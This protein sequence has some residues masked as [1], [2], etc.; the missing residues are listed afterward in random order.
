MYTITFYVG[1]AAV[2]NDPQAGEGYYDY[3]RRTML[4]EA[5]SIFGGYSLSEVS[6]GWFDQA[7]RLVE[8]TSLRLEV[9]TGARGLEHAKLL[10][11]HWAKDWQQDCILVNAVE[12][13]SS[14]FIEPDGE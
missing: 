3:R 6:G 12:L 11:K 7:G 2:K 13:A 8:E 9:T 5:A 10:A 14:D 4:E 1:T